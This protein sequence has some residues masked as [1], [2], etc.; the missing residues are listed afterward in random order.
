MCCATRENTSRS[1]RAS[2]SDLYCA[3]TPNL[4]DGFAVRRNPSVVAVYGE[5]L[6]TL[7]PIVGN[8]LAAACRDGS[9]PSVPTCDR[10]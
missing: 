2:W 8:L 10:N 1:G 3:T 5:N 9:A 6:F 7:A 4:G